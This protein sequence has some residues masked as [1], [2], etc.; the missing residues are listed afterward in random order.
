MYDTSYVEAAYNPQPVAA[1]LAGVGASMVGLLGAPLGQGPFLVASAPLPRGTTVTAE[2]P[3]SPSPRPVPAS[4]P[5]PPASSKGSL[6]PMIMVFI[7]LGMLALFIWLVFF[8][9]WGNIGG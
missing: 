7:V 5:S 8:K 4:V 2:S 9:R 6:R 3:S 1:P